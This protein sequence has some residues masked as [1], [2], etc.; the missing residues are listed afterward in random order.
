MT[1]LVPCDE[2]KKQRD[3]KWVCV[4]P[5]CQNERIVSYAQKWNIETGKATSYCRP[6]GLS[7]GIIKPRSNTASISVEAR[8]KAS[9]GR[10]GKPRPSS[11]SVI[12]YRRLF[13]PESFSNV[14]TK[15]KQRLA[16]L[17]KTGEL[18]NNWQGGK[19]KERQLAMSRDEYKN[20]RKLVLN[21]DNY[22]CQICNIRGGNLE[23]D[24]IKEWCN[25]P[26][27][28]YEPSNC[29]ILCEDCH[30]KTDN[31]LHKAKYKKVNL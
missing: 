31:Y 16:K 26:E 6:C 4:C 2:S 29:R 28:R 19:T 24:H 25:Y 7:C 30:A 18:A 23:M 15:Q 1:T 20:L 21:R 3:T 22:T 12:K 9:K 11:S 17:G 8:K 10:I 5:D 14:N 13:S 27:L